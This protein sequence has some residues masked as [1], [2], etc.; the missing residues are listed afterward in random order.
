MA[1]KAEQSLERL[2]KA[3]SSAKAN[4]T[5]KINKIRELMGN[6]ENLTAVKD[7][8]SELHEVLQD[9]RVVHKAYHSK[10]ESGENDL[11]ES[12]EYCLSVE[13]S[14][15]ELEQQIDS[16][17]R[18]VQHDLE[19]S[20]RTQRLSENN[21][22]QPEDSISNV[23]SRVSSRASSRRSS[24]RSTTSSRAKVAARKAALEVQAATLGRLHEL[25]IEELKLQQRKKELHLRGEIAAAEAEREVY[26]QVEAE[27][28]SGFQCHSSSAK[29][30]P[31]VKSN[32]IPMNESTKHGKPNWTTDNA[33][34]NST[35]VPCHNE[36]NS[37]HD[38]SLRRLAE[39][40]DHQSFTLQQLI[41]Q[42]QQG[43]MAL[44]LPQPSMQVFSGNPIDYCDFIRSFEH[45]VESKTSSPSARLYYLI[46]HT[47]GTAQELMKSCL[48]MHEDEGYREARKLLKERFGQNYRVAAAHVQRVIEGPPIKHEDGSALQ[49]FSIQLTSCTN[50]LERIGYLDKLNNSDNL[51]KIIDRLP[52]S[53]RAN[54]R[55]Y[56][57]R[58]VQ[59]KARDI[60]IKDL[61]EFVT[62]KARATTHPVFGKISTEGKTKILNPRL[63]RHGFSTYANSEGPK[64][65]LCESNHWLSRCD[66]FRK[67][68]LEERQKFVREKKLCNNCLATGH[69]VRSCPKESFCKVQGCSNKHSTFLHPKNNSTP[70]NGN[71]GTKGN[72][73]DPREKETKDDS[74]TANNGYIKSKISASTTVIGLS[75][76]PVPVRTPGSTKTVDTYAF[77]DSGSNTTF[78]T[79]ALLKRLGTDGKKTKLSLTTMQG[80]NTPIECSLVSLN[81]ADLEGTSDIELPMVYSRPTLPV[82]P[83]AISKQEDVNRWPYLKGVK[84]PHI[85]SDVGLLIGCDVPQA[86]QPRE[87]RPSQNGGPF[88]T[89]T[90]LGWVLNGPLG[91]DEEKL[92]TSNFVQA[93]QSLEQQFESYCNLDFND[94]KYDA[95]P[96][97]S[98]NDRKALRIMEQTVTMDNGHY[99]MALPWKTFPPNL[100]N[101]K[102][103]AE[104]RLQMLR[105]RLLK[106]P[107]LLEKYTQYM[108][109][110]LANDYAS[111]AS[112][113]NVGQLET[114]WYLP[115]HPVFHPQKPGKL[116]VVFDCS[117]EY[118]NTSLNKQLLQGPDLTNSLVGVLTRFRQEPIAFI[119]DIE[120]MFH[121]VRVQPTDREALRFLWWP[122]GNLDS[123]PKE[124]RMNVHLF[125]SASSPSCSN[126]ALKKTAADNAAHFD[127]RTIETVQRN[128]YVDDCL[129]S[130]SN[131]D[132]AVKLSAELR[133]LLALG[134]FN[135][136]KWLSNSRKVIES[137]PESERAAQ[138]KDLDFDKAP[139]ERA[140][141][142]RW[143][144]SSD[145]FGFAIVIKD[146]PLTRRGILSIISSIYDA[147]GFVAPFIL[148]A[149]L[150]L[151]DLC[152]LKL[153]WD[154]KI[155]EEFQNRWHAWLSDLPQLEQLAIDRCFK[156]SEM[157]EI[158]S[159]QLH[160]FSDASQQGYGAVSYIRIADNSGKTKCSFVMG[161]SRLA[162]IKLVT[163]P[164]MEL[165][166]AVV[167]TK[168]ERML[169]NE[170]SISIDQSFFWTD[171]TC[172]LRYI[173]NK[174]KRF[175]TFV[176]N[177]IATIHDASSPEQWNYVDTDSN[178]ADEAS[179]GVP[180]N[181]LQRWIE[182]PEFL[183][184][185][186]EAW[187]QR[188]TELCSTVHESD[189][190]I[191]KG[192]TV[193]A[194]NISRTTQELAIIE[195]F[196]CWRRLKRV[197]AWLLRYKRNLRHCSELR[198]QGRMADFKQADPISPVSLEE[199]V[200]AE[201][202]ILKCVQNSCFSDELHRLKSQQDGRNTSN[203]LSKSS[204]IVKLDPIIKDGLIRVGGRLQQ[205]SIDS[206]AQ[207]PIILPINHHV[208]NL[209][210]KF[211]HYESG[212][213]GLEHTLSLIRQRYWIVKAR[214]SVRK[215]LHECVSC[216]KRQ[217]PAVEQ[218]MAS[219]PKDRVT[220]E[221]P[222]FTFTGVDCFGPFEVR[223]G[224]ARAKR[225]GVIFTCLTLRAIH[226]EV[227]NS[228]DTESFINA[229]RRFIA[230]RG[231][232]EEMRSDNGGNFVK[233]EKELRREIQ[234]W[235][236]TQIHD[237]LVQR[238]IKWTFNPPAGS[239]HGGVWERCIRTVRKVMRAITKEQLLDDEGINTLMCEVEAIVN[240]RPLTKLSDDP[241]D[242]EPL[243]PNHLLLLRNGPK[244]PPGIFSKEDNC[245]SRRW[246]QV[247]YLANVFWRRWIREYLPSLQERQKW[248]KTRKNL[249]INDI[250]LISDERTPRCSWPLG[251]VL[252]V[253]TNRRDGLV[254]SVK[255]KTSTSLL[256]RPVDKIILLETE[257]APVNDK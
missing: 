156:S 75:I 239:H 142:V 81:V 203:V 104:N 207:H 161:K 146:R 170:L 136:T 129:K 251:R 220:P 210:T 181:A 188:P 141:G 256:V 28:L 72:K 109:N 38:E 17:L 51:K 150:I 56:V 67:Q 164:R 189:P 243:T 15:R 225:Y 126:F 94:S 49:E 178:P 7:L 48:S 79:D 209:I 137:L 158:T 254:R 206:Y 216:R 40:Q 77:L 54:W 60:N 212:H 223:R 187:P 199:L 240:G 62:A 174:D 83:T 155:P 33:A 101:N 110:L 211:Y 23:G 117:A 58:I 138:V 82:P 27:E 111:E 159:V 201:T 173:E 6:H 234:D 35:H 175:Q 47:S 192:S 248:N 224:R 57:D 100:P 154:D 24:L 90:V 3:R 21:N 5:R 236:Q 219:L 153:G 76:V 232:P 37:V 1:S 149:K 202:Q 50:T 98:Q 157:K 196:S 238:N 31:A 87:V 4:V 52:Y 242:L 139:I 26:E 13:Q 163:I 108:D 166:A 61:N 44:T 130:V 71:E 86:L 168:L 176:A 80:E 172:V 11:R 95:R 151:Q 191:K 65:A 148:T 112:E 182:G 68:S 89:R 66:K 222:P 257:E 235:N 124:Y 147:L 198:K 208:T 250:V 127:D 237:F 214:S 218:K 121:Q 20:I 167:S 179:R 118:H 84:I 197:I 43:V 12:D 186:S 169:R 246:R 244:V 213:S 45:L 160:H 252:E 165:S 144:V 29:T 204:S 253:H 195:R 133:S 185:P 107:E 63:R 105:K 64:C 74:N 91:R 229:L 14:A 131:E 115:H 200:N 102:T 42:Q 134:G 227:A 53:M 140:L 103:Q 113:E 46:Q 217:S 128:F 9:F 143:N 120:A 22:I 247:Q 230:R 36:S 245:S 171:S 73:E 215:V 97:M 233:G 41:Q 70:R 10:I 241:R 59:N 19:R 32:I 183:A 135:L 78:C 184:K 96:T 55:D 8:L 114:H 119:S 122:S 249:M 132:D 180:A 85:D 145:T 69:F 25:E 116:R 106:D 2:R 221:K 231:R 92:P 190:E 152:R 194:T 30:T 228:L 177:R 226:I 193:C 162:P 125:G 39:M 88:A 123:P 16:W 255:V 205:A 18:D 93:N 34:P 99:Q